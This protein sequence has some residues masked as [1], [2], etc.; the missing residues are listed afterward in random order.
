MVKSVIGFIELLKGRPTFYAV[1]SVVTV[2]H[3]LLLWTVSAK[4]PK[5]RPHYRCFF[6][7]ITLTEL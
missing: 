5:Y 7:V 1:T 4:T 6:L 2:V 3:Y